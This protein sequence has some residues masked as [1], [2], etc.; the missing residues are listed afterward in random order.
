MGLGETPKSAGCWRKYGNS[1]TSRAIN[2]QILL[3]FSTFAGRRRRKQWWVGT[4]SKTDN[5][6][7]KFN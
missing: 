3:D 1:W 7:L 6:N 4:D 2:Y 5:K